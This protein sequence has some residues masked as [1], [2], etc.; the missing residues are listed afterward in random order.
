MGCGAEILTD[1]ST[2]G[3]QRGLKLGRPDSDLCELLWGSRADLDVRPPEEPRRTRSNLP[4]QPQ[5]DLLTWL[6]G[7]TPDIKQEP[8]QL[9]TQTGVLSN[10]SPFPL[11][12]LGC[13]LPK[14][15]RIYMSQTGLTWDQRQSVCT[16]GALM[17]R[18]FR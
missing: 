16:S 5:S 6:S 13:Q 2:A 9:R 14:D 8:I 1:H 7:Q 10:P 18:N 3:R 12:L 15:G 17:E 11:S 4:P